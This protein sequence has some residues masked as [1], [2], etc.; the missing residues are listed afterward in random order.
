MIKVTH[1]VPVLNGRIKLS[2]EE[3]DGDPILKIV[4]DE[5][6][7]DDNTVMHLNG[8]QARILLASLRL[9][10]LDL[11]EMEAEDA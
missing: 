11:R 6:C 3:F 1:G 2:V 7:C 10:L 5:D 8:S 9:A 4:S